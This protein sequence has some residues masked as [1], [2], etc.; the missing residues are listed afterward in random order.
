[1]ARASFV[2]TQ[3]GGVESGLK[4]AL[5]S[6]FDYV[7]SN[8]RFGPVIPNTRT[9]NFT[10]RYYTGTTHTTPDTEFSVKHEFQ[11]LKPYLLI[12]VLDLTAVNGVLPQLTVTRA[13]D[14]ERVYLK[15]PVAGAT[16]TF[17]LEG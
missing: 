14:R 7:L 8:L 10:G 4:R 11:G 6:I 13:A 9:E 1:M 17:Y 16:F 15:S 2:E 12:P 5:K 3:L